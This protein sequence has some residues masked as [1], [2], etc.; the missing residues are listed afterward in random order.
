MRCVMHFVMQVRQALCALAGHIRPMPTAAGA[1][2]AAAGAGMAAATAVESEIGGVTGIDT[3]SGGPWSQLLAS[4]AL[5]MS[6]PGTHPPAAALGPD[7]QVVG[8]A[9]EL[10]GS[11]PMTG[12]GLQLLQQQQG[13]WHQLQPAAGGGLGVLDRSAS[14]SG[15]AAMPAAAVQQQQQAAA[16]ASAL[17][18]QTQAQDSRRAGSQC[19][20]REGSAAA[21]QP[22]LCA[23]DGITDT[24]PQQME[25]GQHSREPLLG[26]AV[27]SG[28]TQP[29]TAAAPDD[30]AAGAPQRSRIDLVAA[31]AAEGSGVTADVNVVPPAAGTEQVVA[32]NTGLPVPFCST[33]LLSANTVSC[34]Q[35]VPAGTAPAQGASS[36]WF[37]PGAAAEVV[38]RA[39]RC[40]QLQQP[41]ADP[42]DQLPVHNTVQ[43]AAGMR[44]TTADQVKQ[45]H[46]HLPQE[47]V[48][49]MA[50]ITHTHNDVSAPYQPTA[51]EQR[52]LQDA[53]QQPQQQ[54]EDMVAAPV[55]SFPAIC[56]VQQLQR[57]QEQPPFKPW[58]AAA[59]YAQLVYA[60]AAAAAPGVDGAA[61][62]PAAEVEQHQPFELPAWSAPPPVCQ[63]LAAAGMGMPGEGLAAAGLVRGMVECRPRMAAA[64]GASGA[65][66]LLDP[67]Y[68]LQDPA[69]AG[70]LAQSAGLGESI[71]AAAMNAAQ[72][73]RCVNSWL[74]W[75]ACQLL[76]VG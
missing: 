15:A 74:W 55:T 16:T 38:P 17:M 3:S 58:G 33:A 41:R 47:P 63:P 52:L 45:E 39:G 21:E 13:I 69:S 46:D 53:P 57:Q 12:A 68:I 48:N 40:G 1:A 11:L 20:D 32:D 51:E 67:A 56:H 62:A 75:L 73:L 35:G 43:Q 23:E 14:H 22:L 50:A 59:T 27:F 7:Q 28:T 29:A 64:A 24:T 34:S 44:I 25:Q 42:Q 49:G 19:S 70:Q 72:F 9:G 61:A 2:A 26:Q 37:V 10:D 6:L 30:E 4:S 65:L 60:D 66:P 31:A 8:P 18:A 36:E 54:P 71:A 76:L 5:Q